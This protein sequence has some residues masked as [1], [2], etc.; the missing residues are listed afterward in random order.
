MEDQYLEEYDKYIVPEKIYSSFL[1]WATFFS[2]TDFFMIHLI[3][4]IYL[5]LLF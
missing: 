3:Y 1:H 4:L 2:D 5:F